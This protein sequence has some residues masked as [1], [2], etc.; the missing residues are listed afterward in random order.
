[1]ITYEKSLAKNYNKFHEIPP[2][3]FDLQLQ[4]IKN[5]LSATKE[6]WLLDV[7]C[8]AG[9]LL[10]PI[11]S[12]G[13]SNVVGI[14][15]SRDMF[16]QLT[17]NLSTLS[18]Y[19]VNYLLLNKDFREVLSNK[20]NLNLPE[21]DGAYF[22]FSLHQIGQNKLDQLELLEQTFSLLKPHAPILVITITERQFEDITINKLIPSVSEI[23]K[24]RFLTVDSYRN[25]FNVSVL[26][27]QRIFYPITV[28]TLKERIQ[29]RYIST[30][31]LIPQ[32]E[33]DFACEQ[34]SRYPEHRIIDYGNCFTYVVLNKK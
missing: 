3:I 15:R 27:D 34:L 33:L 18:D 24:E 31:Q 10:N 12:Q 23:D 13:I 7:G 4:K 8:G 9:R 25:F 32:E 2:H 16:Q 14:E 22:S 28:K 21:L 6:T 5:Y 20:S 1:M 30:L 11:I 19:P 17:D 26:E 29:N